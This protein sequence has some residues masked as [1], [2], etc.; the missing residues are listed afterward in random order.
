MP[1]GPSRCSITPEAPRRFD[2]LEFGEIEFDNRPQGVGERA[3][4]LI[5]RQRVQPAGIFSLQLQGRGYGVIPPLDPGA[6][7]GGTACADNW[8]ASRVRGA[9]TRLT[10][11][12]G[13]RCFTDRL[14]HGST[15]RRYVTRARSCRHR[16]GR[17][18]RAP[19]SLD[20]L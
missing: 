16:V 17:G 10:F 12:A 15:P 1:Y 8:C 9:I 11:G 13:H 2:C 18:G 5:V 6:P 3:V 7:V 20:A 19:V 4:L 14:R